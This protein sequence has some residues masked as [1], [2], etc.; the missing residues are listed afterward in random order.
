MCL[1]C[2][3]IEMIKIGQGDAHLHWH[4][5]LRVS[6]D[7]GNYENNGKEPIWWYP[8]DLM[9]S[10]DNRPSTEELEEM[11]CRLCAELDRL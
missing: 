11:K 6:G 2:D 9:Y 10:D 3:R 7:L 1:I 4:L 8:M 5:S